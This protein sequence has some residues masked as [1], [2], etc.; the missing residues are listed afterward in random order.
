MRIKGIFHELVA[1]LVTWLVFYYLFPAP[2]LPDGSYIQR[3]LAGQVFSKFIVFVFIF[4]VF[5]LIS[6]VQGFR[7]INGEFLKLIRC[8]DLEC[9]EKLDLNSV[10]RNMV[11]NFVSFSRK[12]SSKT[13]LI[14]MFDSYF[15]SFFQWVEG[16]F[17][18]VRVVIWS[19][20]LM[21]FIG[22]VV[23]VS[24]AI[25]GFKIGGKGTE[26][27]VQSFSQVSSGLYTAFDTTFLGLVL[28]LIL[29]FIY[30]LYWRGVSSKLILAKTHLV[31]R[32][33]PELVFPAE[34]EVPILKEEYFREI[35]ERLR[36]AVSEMEKGAK[37]L[38]SLSRALLLSL[39]EEEKEKLID[40]LEK[41][42]L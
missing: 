21:G 34:G 28:V 29:M 5:S 11:E 38:T 4:G 18:T 8:N 41:G 26:G 36:A 31:E 10:L 24:F 37:F 39:A 17:S 16:R 27:F 20:P 35:E 42:E 22:T 19:L 23:G 40:E 7:N 25:A 33:V 6:T 9:L 2:F 13:E 12:S 30:S 14:S 1:S 32:I 3:V 15:Q